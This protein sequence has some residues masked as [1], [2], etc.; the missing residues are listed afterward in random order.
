MDIGKNKYRHGRESV[1][2]S[3]PLPGVTDT[4]IEHKFQT[5]TSVADFN[6]SLASIS[7]TFYHLSGE[8]YIYQPTRMVINVDQHITD[9]FFINAELTI[10]FCHCCQ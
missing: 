7:Q 8:F 5:V 4:L 6:D 2:A 3:N 9:N 10:P 1:F